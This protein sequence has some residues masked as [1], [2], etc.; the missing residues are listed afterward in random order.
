MQNSKRPQPPAASEGARRGGY[1]V[2]GLVFA[3]VWFVLCWPWLSGRV[4]I[5]WD[6]KAHFYP[7]F[8]FL[9]R[10]LARGEPPFW[11]PNIF[12][13]W[14][15]IADPQSLI[16]A[17]AYLLAALLGPKPGFELADGLL[18]GMLGLGALGVFL[19][20][21]DRGWRAEGA[22]VAAIAFAFGGSA[23]WRIQHV[24]QVMSFAWF[25]LALF[26]LSRALDRSSALWG[27]AAGVLAGFMVI[28]RDQVAWLQVLILA[29]FVLH[30][31]F[32]PGAVARRFLAPLG[33]GFVA[34]V[35]VAGVPVAFTLALAAD[36]NRPELVF[37]EVV[38]GSL[39]PA[40]LLTLVAPN[41]F[42]TDGPLSLFW[43]PPS[44]AWGPIDLILARNM[45]DVYMGALVLV[46]LGAAGVRLRGGD[47][48]VGFFA[49][50]ALVLL[51]YAI[52]RYTPAFGLLFH[53]PGADLWRRPADATF[54]LGAMLAYLAGYGVHRLSAG[55]TRWRVARTAAIVGILFLAC[56][57][58]ALGRGR[59]DQAVGS[60]LMAAIMLGG[61]FALLG[62]IARRPAG[63]PHLALVLIGLFC[64]LDLGLGNGPNE[65][66]GL[67]PA[68]FDMLRPDSNNT[69]I[70]L[71]REK[72]AA[73]TAPDRRDRIELAG[74]GFDWPNASLSQNFDHD[75]GYNPLRLALFEKFTAAEDTVGL[76]EQR[77]FSKA[78]PSYRSI[79]ADLTGLRYIAT[80][81]PIEEIDPK[82][83]PGDL[84]FVA[85]TADAWIYEN[86]RAMPRV[87]VATAARAADFGA[88][89]RTGVWPDADYRSTVLLAAGGDQKSRRPGTA[90]ILSY[91]NA[92]IEVEAEAPDGGWLVLTDIYHPWWEASLDGRP[93]PIEQADV[94]FRAVRLPPGKHRLSF[95]FRPFTGLLREAA[96]RVAHALGSP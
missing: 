64:A 15:Q 77:T 43:G 54:P 96:T 18:F 59:L 28:G 24:G 12:D 93:A 72:L 91:G 17:P 71:L 3:A 37:S 68:R 14:P 56:L 80:G 9:A 48:D 49:G 63:R 22:L 67:P 2:A 42:G 70:R 69:T 57:I 32:A 75:L 88:I 50:A 30:R 13:G 11:T 62:W 45:G 61:A 35:L 38:K 82:L 87:F 58:L 36:S 41:L 4:T 16:F 79:A 34:G 51:L 19:Y 33:A 20:A 94:A 84:K 76:P 66:T 81:V 25:P 92:R 1:L 10:S 39:H 78:F 7:Q 95:R 89:V 47:R 90:R 65:S 46:A 27:A 60:L 40:S 52:G 29:T 74:I 55:E 23:A 83:K 86:P 85:R 53:L 6:A 31:L 5:P 26:A 8:V 44:D 73:A 21:R